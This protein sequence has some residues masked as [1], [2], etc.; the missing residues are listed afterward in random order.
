MRNV[1]LSQV[2]SKDLID[3]AALAQEFKDYLIDFLG[4]E[5]DEAAFVVSSDF[6]NPYNAP[7]IMQDY[8]G[9]VTIDGKDYEVRLCHTDFSA[10]GLFHLANVPPFEFYMFFD[11]ETMPDTTVGSYRKAR[12]MYLI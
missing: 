10:C 9:I 2:T 3:H 4:Y 6:A 12:K 5:D 7:F 11:R 1:N 8:E